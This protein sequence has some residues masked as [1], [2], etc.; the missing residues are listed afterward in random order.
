MGWGG[1]N[2]GRGYRDSGGTGHRDWCD[3]DGWTQDGSSWG[4]QGGG[5]GRG[6]DRGGSAKGKATGRGKGKDIG[7]MKPTDDP[8]FVEWSE[9]MRLNGSQR[10]VSYV[11]EAYVASGT[12]SRVFRVTEAPLEDADVAS[13]AGT[14]RRWG[15][16]GDSGASA[17]TSSS[18][19]RVMAAKVMRKHDSYIQYTSDAKKEGELLQ[20]LE[21]G[22]VEAGR[23]VLTMRCLD[24][25]PTR[26]DA[27]QEYWCLIFE[28][29]DASLFDVVK[30]NSNSGLHL[31]M[32]R[33]LLEQLLQQLRVL[34]ENECTHTD[35]KHKNCC[36]ADTEHAFVRVEGEDWPTLVLA[37]PLAKFIDYGNAVFEGE[38]KTHPIHTKQ[39]RAP[40][41]LLNVAQ[42]WGPA[43]DTWTLGV[44][45]AFLISG[46]LFFD[47]HEPGTLI[48]TMVEVLGP[49]PQSLLEDAKDNRIRA[50]AEKAARSRLDAQPQLARWLGFADSAPNTPEAHCVD[51]LRRMLTLDP[52]DRIGA[53]Q[54]LRHP[55]IT[56]GLPRLPPI[57]KNAPMKTL[58]GAGG[59]GKGK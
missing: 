16:E 42:G 39:F 37:R 9:G 45:I 18:A 54:A 1:R 20:S 35:I 24:S 47:S 4:K 26:D 21:R 11:V 34:Q 40:E 12:F 27:N 50:V 25:F 56:A 19:P 29:L 32:V 17:A 55:F 52:A 33:I 14:K 43:S 28:W 49:F 46:Q 48:Q 23:P 15:K 31:S 59:H 22:Q 58:V 10:G 8:G 5:R 6:G 3:S 44:T 41:V 57:P 7:R 36:L 38:K 13:R 51:L 30:A 53:E 2:G